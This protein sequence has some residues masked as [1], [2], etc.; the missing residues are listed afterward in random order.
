M[1]KS[2]YI[3]FL[4]LAPS[5]G[6]TGP[7]CEDSTPAA[8]DCAFNRMYNFDFPGVFSTLDKLERKDPSYPVTYSVR[9][10][11]MLF[12]ELYRL[13]ILETEFFSSDEKVIGTKLR[14]DPRIRDALF[15]ATRDTRRIAGARLASDPADRDAMFAM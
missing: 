6:A 10:A 4:L 12:S 14:A 5:A 2:L 9:A 15:K 7:T 13:R 11:G 8:I 1:R 3:L